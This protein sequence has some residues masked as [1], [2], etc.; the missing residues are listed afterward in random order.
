MW[1]HVP[2]S[3][4]EPDVAKARTMERELSAKEDTEE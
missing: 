3:H 4:W 1:W 2:S